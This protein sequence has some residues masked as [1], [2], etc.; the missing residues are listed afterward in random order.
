MDDKESRET[1][2][3]QETQEN[4]ETIFWWVR[5]APVAHGGLL[6][7][8]GSDWPAEIDIEDRLWPRLAGSLPRDAVWV[9]SGLRRAQETSRA[10]LRHYSLEASGVSPLIEEDFNEQRFGRWEGCSY[11][12][13]E[14]LHPRSW[15][16]FWQEPHGYRPPEGESFS[17]QVLRVRG[18]L[19]G[20]MAR[21][22]GRDIVIV[23]HGGTIRAALTIALD[24]PLERSFS[25]RIDNN[26][27]SCTVY[28]S[29]HPYR[30]WRRALGIPVDGGEEV[31]S[32]EVRFCNFCHN[33]G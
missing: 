8:G 16:A 23:C 21:Y 17:D 22:S 32:W 1:Q 25:I 29:Q 30:G 33:L 6:Y 26:S 15:G 11:Q 7:G 12:E 2:E 19:E 27:L 14:R 4:R 28:H 5:H 20:L 24:I 13:L 9:T 10:I 31:G 3:T 18:G